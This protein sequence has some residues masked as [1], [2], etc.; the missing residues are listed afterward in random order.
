MDLSL[1]HI[2]ACACTHGLFHDF[3]CNF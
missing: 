3:H 2:T 1:S